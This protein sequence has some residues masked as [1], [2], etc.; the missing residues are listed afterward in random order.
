MYESF[1]RYLY[2]VSVLDSISAIAKNPSAKPAKVTGQKP[3]QVTDFSANAYTIEVICEDQD[4]KLT[5]FKKID[6][7]DHHVF[8]LQ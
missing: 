7:Q 6:M 3:K 5:N 4:T 8:S 1:N 2:N